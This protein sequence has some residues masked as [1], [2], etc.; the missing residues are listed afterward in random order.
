MS[1]LKVNQIRAKLR[2]MFEPHLDLSDIGD[3]DA[4]REPKILSRCLAALAVCLQTGCTEKE[5]AAAVWDGGDDNGIDAAYFDTSASR[6]L[7]VQAKW[8]SKGAGEPEAKEI[9]AFVKGVRD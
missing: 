7:F 8:I 2:S 4:E 3:T 1:S 5:A 9:G 6:V